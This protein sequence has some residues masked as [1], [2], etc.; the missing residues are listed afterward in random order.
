MVDCIEGE[1]FRSHKILYICKVYRL[2]LNNE[3]EDKKKCLL[4]KQ[5]CKELAG[6]DAKDI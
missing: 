1:N 3:D 5:T 4:E 6:A 2:S